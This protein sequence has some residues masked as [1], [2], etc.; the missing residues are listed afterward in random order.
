[1]VWEYIYPGPPPTSR[2]VASDGPLAWQTASA[3]NPNA[4]DPRYYGQGSAYRAVRYGADFPGFKGKDL[5]PGQTLT[6]RTPRLVGEGIV[7]QSSK[8][9][10]GFTTTGSGGGG[11]G[12]GGTGGGGGGGY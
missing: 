12:T 11:G 5:T 8:T 1:V 3:T 6:G 7:M 9:G 4:G 10:F 2:F